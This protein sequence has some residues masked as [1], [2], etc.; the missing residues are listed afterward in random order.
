MAPKRVHVAGS[1]SR[2]NIFL[3]PTCAEHFKLIE[4]KGVIQERSIDFHDITF[5]PEMETTAR[6]YSWMDFNFLIGESN[7]SW[8]EEFYAN[9]LG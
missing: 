6:Y 5:L 8:V 1:S 3:S 4:K 7:A 9:A 2:Q